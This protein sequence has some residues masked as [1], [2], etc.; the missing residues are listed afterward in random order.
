VAATRINR[1]WLAGS[2]CAV[3]MAGCVP[4]VPPELIVALD[5]IDH[6]LIALGAPQA[7]PE[8]YAYFA[9][10]WVSLRA[11]VHADDD[12]IRWPWESNDIE[13]ELRRLQREG[14]TTVVRLNERRSRQRSTAESTVT[15]L[16]QR[17]LAMASQ[18]QSFDGR[19]AL[20]EKPVQTDLLIKQARLFFEQ[21]DYARSIQAAEQASHALRIQTTALTQELGRYADDRQLR[22]W[23][24][25]VKQTVDWS[26]THQSTAIV[27][28]KAD[29]ELTLY[30][31]GRRV[32]SYPVRLGFNGIREKLFQ[33]DGATPEGRYRV[34]DARGAGQTQF[35]RAL[36]LDYPNTEDRRRFRMAKQSGKIALTKNIGGQIEIHGVESE[37][38]AQ[39]LGCIMLDNR[40]M[41]ELFARVSSGTPVTIVGALTGS[42]SIALALSQLA[43]QK[44]KT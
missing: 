31:N 25:M 6:D 2:I 43:D 39:T 16:E 37:L 15:R 11:R 7:A 28:S 3:L 38:M 5:A 17:F 24:A 13:E 33:G 9:R 19:V 22:Q 8:E 44:D 41:A 36:V 12:L 4:A 32:L 40:H 23:Q 30:K 35:Y 34:I 18:V 21:K 42:N 20:G 1:T 27:V 26:R 29:R 14:G 10:Q